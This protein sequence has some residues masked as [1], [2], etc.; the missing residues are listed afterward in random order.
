MAGKL[1][2]IT[3]GMFSG[4]SSELMRFGEKHTLAK[5]KVV[6]VKPDKDNR[7]S[8]TEIV[9]HS[10]KKV[11]ALNVSI[12]MGLCCYEEIEEADVILIDEV[13][14]FNEHVILDINDLLYEGK[15]VYVSGLDLAFDGSS[16]TITKEL[17]AQAEDIIK[18]KAVCEVCGQDGWISG[19]RH[20]L[21]GEVF[22]LGQKETYIP[23][24]RCCY[25]RT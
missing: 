17:M 3:G 12:T 1:T 23:L 7:Y 24:C 11:T 22:K 9:T 10:G 16:F 4:K 25:A 21:G 6:Y 18:L 15:I 20:S 8:E 13:Q 5:K 19:R 2:V 14:F